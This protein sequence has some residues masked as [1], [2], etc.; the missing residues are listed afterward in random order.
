MIDSSDIHSIRHILPPKLEKKDPDN[1]SILNKVIFKHNML[2]II[3]NF[4]TIS[5]ETLSQLL[6]IDQI[7]L[8]VM[9]EKSYASR[10]VSIDQISNYLQVK[11]DPL[12]NQVFIKHLF[13]EM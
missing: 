8:L 12:R 1:I 7:D 6:N 11:A 13:N 5:L 9:I 10:E 3:K 4:Q 2:P